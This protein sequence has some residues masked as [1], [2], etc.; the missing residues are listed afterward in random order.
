MIIYNQVQN[1][2]QFLFNSARCP[3]KHEECLGAVQDN[4]KT[5]LALFRTKLRMLWRLPGQREDCLGAVQYIKIANIFAI[6]QKKEYNDKT[7]GGQKLCD[8]LRYVASIITWLTLFP[9]PLHQIL[10]SPLLLHLL[11]PHPLHLHCL[12][13]PLLLLVCFFSFR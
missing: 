4:V 9:P 10:Y 3:G 1:Y 13:Q 11:L 2:F 7:T 5:A 8:L 12:L 6:S